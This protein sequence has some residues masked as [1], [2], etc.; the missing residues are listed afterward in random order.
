MSEGVYKQLIVWQKSMKLVGLIYEITL[1][2][3][4]V[5][6][7]RLVD[8]LRRAAI[9]I[10][11]NIVEGKYRHSRRDRYRFYRIAYASCAEVDTQ[12]CIAHKLHFLSDEQFASLQDLVDQIFRI[13]NSL[14]KFEAKS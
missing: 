9:S 1:Q 3:P 8:Q 13:L 4:E 12:L 10:P 2:F 7:P 6:Q 14:M 11:S 5:E